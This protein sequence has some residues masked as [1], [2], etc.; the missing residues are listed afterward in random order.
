MD[1]LGCHCERVEEK[2]S[3]K[4]RNPVTKHLDQ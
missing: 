4:R 3:A 1:N 2:W